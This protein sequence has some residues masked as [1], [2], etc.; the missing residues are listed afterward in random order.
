MVICD[1]PGFGGSATYCSMRHVQISTFVFIFFSCV[2][3]AVEMCGVISEWS[4]QR[5]AVENL[6]KSPCCF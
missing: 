6:H 5:C 3:A 1:E 2:V 4:S